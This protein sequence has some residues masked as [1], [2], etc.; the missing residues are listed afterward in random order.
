MRGKDCGTIRDWK[1]LRRHYNAVQDLGS[2]PVTEEGKKPLVETLSN[3][4]MSCSLV[5]TILP[6]LIS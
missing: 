5:N 3:Q 1:T 2:D 6:K 4:N